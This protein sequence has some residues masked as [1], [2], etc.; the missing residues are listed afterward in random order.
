M[1]SQ[2]LTNN[3]GKNYAPYKQQLNLR[4]ECSYWVHSNSKALYGTN[5]DWKSLKCSYILSTPI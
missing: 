1:L 5:C 2:L 3:K 4:D